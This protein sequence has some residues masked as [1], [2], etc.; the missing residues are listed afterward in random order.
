MVNIALDRHF[1][2][3]R[4][5]FENT[6]YLVVFVL[7][8]GLNIEVHLRGIAQRLEEVKEH[9]GG[10]LA[11]LFAVELGIP[12]QP[13]AASEVEAHC[14]KAIVHRQR[15]TVAFDAALAVGKA[16]GR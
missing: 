3:T 16:C 10:H 8:F 1:Q 5:G 6:L 13:R 7:S 9:L 2:S 14:A 4:Q 11:Y 15:V 12:Y